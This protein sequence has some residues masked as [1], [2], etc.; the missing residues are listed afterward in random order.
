MKRLIFAAVAAVFALGAGP[1]G[2]ADRDLAA[3]VKA[4]ERAFAKT[5]ADRDIQAFAGYIAEEGLFFGG[6]GPIRGREAVVTAWKRFFEGGEAPFSWDPE[7][8]EVLPS[9][10]LGLTSGPVRDPKGEL[11]GTFTTIWRLETDGK[12]RVVFDKGCD[13]CKPEPEQAP[14]KVAEEKKG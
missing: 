3:E 7:T 9:G 2:A 6:K 4:A 5:M 11:I 14:K 1:V 10:N 12:W 13:V 8:A